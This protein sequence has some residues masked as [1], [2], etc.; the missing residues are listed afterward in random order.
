MSQTI[1]RQDHTTRPCLTVR[2][3]VVSATC[4]C[5]ATWS[6]READPRH[7]PYAE[8]AMTHTSASYEQARRAYDA[9]TGLRELADLIARNPELAPVADNRLLMFVLPDFDSDEPAAAMFARLARMLGGTRTKDADD[10]YVTVTRKFGPLAVDVYT[11]RDLV[12]ERV[13]VGTET[14][15]VPDP[16]APKVTVERE[17]VEWKCTPVLANGAA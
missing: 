1:T 5:G 2:D 3:E 9:A 12:C 11:T 14:V 17:V 10:T 7:Q 13:V 16:N 15:E 4:S 6:A 8:W